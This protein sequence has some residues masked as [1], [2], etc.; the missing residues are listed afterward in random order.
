MK[1]TNLTTLVIFLT[2][3]MNVFA[4][5]ENYPKFTPATTYKQAQKKATE[6][7]KKMTLEEKLRMITGGSGFTLYG[8]ERLGMPSVT[9][10]DATG[11]VNMS[12]GRKDRIKKTVAFPAP[13]AV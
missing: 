6:I 2:M 13:V 3:G 12:S 1:K 4:A 7:V 9:M 10:S 11:G 8:I 5:E